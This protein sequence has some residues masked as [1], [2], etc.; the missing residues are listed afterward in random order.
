MCQR[1]AQPALRIFLDFLRNCQ[2]FTLSNGNT[3]AQEMTSAIST[4]SILIIMESNWI[5]TKTVI[6]LILFVL[7]VWLNQINQ[8]D[9]RDQFKR[10]GSGLALRHRVRS[11]DAPWSVRCGLNL[12][13][14]CAMCGSV[15]SASSTVSRMLK[16]SASV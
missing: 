1:F 8:R 4:E 14:R 9:Q 12:P 6:W 10:M 15:I 7:F 16:K 3:K 5:Q 2:V 13:T 11:R